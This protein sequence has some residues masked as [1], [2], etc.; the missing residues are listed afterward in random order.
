MI[1]LY[2]K[3]PSEFTGFYLTKF[4][5]KVAAHYPLTFTNNKKANKLMHSLLIL[6]RGPLYVRK[7]YCSK[8]D[9]KRWKK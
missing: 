9:L 2:L 5:P 3:P 7:G 6:I 4:D 1:K 8:V